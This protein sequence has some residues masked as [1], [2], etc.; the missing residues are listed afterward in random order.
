MYK[1]EFTLKQHTPLIHF[2]HDQ[3]GAT[4]RA[5]EVKPKLDQF[6]IEK[7]LKEQNV[8]FDFYELQAD[9]K[10]KFINAHEAFKRKAIKPENEI[11]NKWAFWLVGKGKNEHVALDYKLHIFQEH[12]PLSYLITN[13][14]TKEQKSILQQNGI[15]YISD[16]PYFAQEKEFAD[17]FAHEWIDGPNGRKKKIAIDLLENWQEQVTHWGFLNSSDP[18]KEQKLYVSALNVE[19]R[20]TIAKC[21][22]QF[23]AQENFGLRQSKG[24]GCFSIQKKQDGSIYTIHDFENDL[25]QNFKFVFW[26]EIRFER[27]EN[28]DRRLSEIY[29][30]I[31][32]DYKLLKSGRNPVERTPYVKSKLFLYMLPDRWEKRF[33]KRQINSNPLTI[34]DKNKIESTIKLKGINP[35]VYNQDSFAWEDSEQL[36]YFFVRALLGLSDHYDFLAETSSSS[37]GK[38]Y[39]YTVQVT[40]NDQIDRYKS[41][42]TFKV[43]ENSIYIVGTDVNKELLNKSF[44]FVAKLKEDEKALISPSRNL[45]SLKTPSSFNLYDFMNSALSNKKDEKISNYSRIKPLPEQ[46]I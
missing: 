18:G 43:Y 32:S 13:R 40:S 35:P 27:K 29:R 42:L 20:Q 22:A 23:F 21:I 30:T 34:I 46:N 39:K 24:F 26:K 19:L 28:E 14:L 17:M 1:L 7:L 41:P 11:Q 33:I 9:G 38:S 4:L 8:K 2:Q 37:K 3:A 6:I 12:N 31:Q 5:T 15:K 36:N 16:C 45:S 10:Q 25:R 44:E